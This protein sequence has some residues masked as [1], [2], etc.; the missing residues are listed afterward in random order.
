MKFSDH[1][2]H[3]DFEALPKLNLLDLDPEFGRLVG[4]GW[5]SVQE[6]V[7][8]KCSGPIMKTIEEAK[9]RAAAANEAS[10]EGVELITWGDIQWKV[11][12]T[13]SKGGF[14][15]RLETEDV[16]VMMKGPNSPWGLSIR[17][18]SVGLWLRGWEELGAWVRDLVR[19][20]FP[21][22]G[23]VKVTRCDWCFDFYSPPF[24]DQFNAA[25]MRDSI[26]MHSS[27]K[28][29]LDA[30]IVGTSKR[31]ET[32]TFG[33]KKNL[34]SQLYDKTKEI[35]DV[36]GKEYFYEIWAQMA[37]GE[38]LSKHVW[39]LEIRMG[40]EFLKNRNCRSPE[41]VAQYRPYLI[42]DAIARQRVTEPT[43]DSNRDRWPLHPFWSEAF[44]RM[45]VAERPP[46][47]R[48][49]SG[50][51]DALQDLLIKQLAG[52]ARTAEV[53][54]LG[55]DGEDL[56]ISLQQAMDVATADP[57]AK[58]KRDQARKRYK[59]VKGPNEQ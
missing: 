25:K 12:A 15:Y 18:K 39:R 57:D 44:R 50:Q 46:L 47:G 30:G 4:Y 45:N 41:N 19:A 8:V 2:E 31:D 5:D 6:A 38:V 10:G 42:A 35:T 9:V 28:A 54:R 37:D 59:Y 24:A 58:K 40:K 17:Y 20:T 32:L 36:S 7:E 48:Y 3:L 13:G 55:E 53:L 21:N 26:V 23:D 22:A 14:R 52:V 49:V 33:S 29:R 11:H 51:R 43:N 34:Q 27:S 56:S 16:I 1:I